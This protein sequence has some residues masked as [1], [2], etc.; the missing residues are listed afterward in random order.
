[1][2]Y[3]F[4]E[5]WC[6]AFALQYLTGI[7]ASFGLNVPS[8]L[9]GTNGPGLTLGSAE[10]Y[11]AF[12][13]SFVGAD[14]DGSLYHSAEGFSPITPLFG[15]ALF[16]MFL[17]FFLIY[18]GISKGI[19]MFCKLAMPLLILCSL[20]ILVRVVTLPNPTGEVGRS[21]ADGLG[22]MWNPARPGRTLWDSLSNPDVWLAATSQIFYSVSVGF[23]LIVTY[24]SYVR[25]KEDIA[26][27]S[28]TA[29][30]SNELCEVVLA[31]LMILPPAVMF[32]GTSGIE[33]NLG[34]FSLGFN[35]L[36]N[37]FEQMAFG[38]FFG[39]LF[40]FLLFLAAVTS[41]ISMVQPTV[42]LLEEGL[43][44]GRK[45]S[46]CLVCLFTLAGLMI[47][48]HFTKALC[49]LDTFDFWV[50]NFSLFCLAMLQTF[51]IA[52]CW[53]PKKM[54]TELESGAK[55]RV[56]VSVG[57]VLKYIS[58]PYLGIIFL[59]WLSKN[60]KGR[61]TELVQSPV[62]QLVAAFLI[63]TALF[64][65]FVTFMALRRW[66]KSGK[67]EEFRQK[68]AAEKNAQTLVSEPAAELGGTS[69]AGSNEER[70]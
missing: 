36:P 41:S 52:W 60:A 19:E 62:A 1:M 12:F 48:C 67:L 63:L 15:C 30:A 66:E 4:I 57:W 46:I 55:I 61:F 9:A 7:L 49:A 56:P 26:L 32:L 43:N 24:A 50:G 31:G 6:L 51:L 29:T 8:F 21:F 16:C 14:A 38:Q 58:V 33:G 69:D 13:N 45:R 59:F 65:A 2:Y 37:V 39:F 42:A 27:S 54:H 25:P 44:F 28:L 3:L 11:T 10:A 23:G 70:A 40:F 64:Y 47:L 22:F 18:R 20:L 5:A 53:G 17:N 34:V 68:L 35:V